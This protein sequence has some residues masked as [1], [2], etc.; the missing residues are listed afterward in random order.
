MVE[1]ALPATPRVKRRNPY[2]RRHIEIPADLESLSL[3]P[4]DENPRV[5]SYVFDADD[6]GPMVWTRC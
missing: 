6:C 2:R 3:E 5:D 1:I 4:D